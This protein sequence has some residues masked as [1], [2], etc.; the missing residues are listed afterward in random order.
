MLRHA[1]TRTRKSE[2]TEL[3]V[4]REPVKKFVE[5]D[6]DGPEW[7]FYQSVTD[8]VRRYAVECGISDGF[9][10]A[11]PQRQ[12]SSCM[13]AAAKAW[14]EKVESYEEQLYEDFGYADNGSFE[15]SPLIDRLRTE[16]LSDINLTELR[17]HD[18]KYELFRGAILGYLKDNPGEKVIVF[19]FF[20]KTLSYLS[21][22]LYEDGVKSQVLV[23]GMKE[24]KQD[25]IERFR[26][27]SETRILLSSEVASEG[28]D[29]QFCRVLV[30]Y[31]L[32]WN[33][34]KVEQRIGRIDRIGQ[35]AEKISIINLLYANTID[36]KIHERLYVRLKIFERALGGMEA[37][38]GEEIS[39]LTS[40]LLSRPLTEAQENQRIDQTAMAV[41]KIRQD[42]DEL[43][44]QASHL[45]AHG[46]YILD[47]VQAAHQF[48]K[49]ITEQDLVAYV[50]DY[51]E[52]YCQGYE[53]TQ[54]ASDELRFDIRLPATAAAALDDFIK[55]KKLYGQTRLATGE[56]VRSLFVNRVRD[57]RQKVELISQFHPLIRFV[58]H[59][60][61]SKDEAFY[62]LVAVRVSA[63][64]NKDF[65]KG[66]YAFFVSR[67]VF[68]GI[69]VEEELPV[70]AVQICSGK[71]LSREESW[72]LLN[73]ARVLGTDW[74]SVSNTIDIDTF[75]HAL[76]DCNEA[77]EADYQ[78]IRR[79]RTNENSDRV[80]FQIE[81]AQRHRDRQLQ[82][83][84]EIL[85]R[86][87]LAGNTRM[88]PPTEGRIR[89]VKERFDV[90]VEKLRQRTNLT[91]SQFEVCCG[92][93]QWQ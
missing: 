57:P 64:E 31:D 39:E 86:Y 37:I 11:G 85:G 14:K 4:I 66:E 68:T 52:K 42:Q 22:R 25:I 36:H 47:E 6:P 27:N 53:F 50:K 54:L 32:P 65:E 28:V 2:V 8:A 56:I 70:R 92:V 48:K 35:E 15:L 16:V 44:Q 21:E 51:L 49:R 19:S 20:R 38:L 87:R 58:S 82:T 84:Y 60:L 30:N 83:R 73:R 91:S 41:E 29:L 43:E 80:N 89:K 93:I 7:A 26:E 59:E 77:L 12:V 10:L 34:M 76:D 88:I 18:S 81:S 55:K 1:I 67:W 74:L 72:D 45:I 3:R 17:E 23:G 69:K 5:L 61:Q 33:P 24:I 9:L 78:S 71:L 63:D 46:G 13:Y 79:Q 62:P 90:Q 75:V 40:A